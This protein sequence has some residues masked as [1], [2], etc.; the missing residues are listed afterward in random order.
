MNIAAHK[1][2]VPV[3]VA[4]HFARTPLAMK[5]RATLSRKSKASRGE[6]AVARAWRAAKRASFLGEGRAAQN[7]LQAAG[8]RGVPNASP[9]QIIGGLKTLAPDLA[10]GAGSLAVAAWA[11]QKLNEKYKSMIP[12]SLQQHAPALLS[13]AIGIGGYAAARKIRGLNRF[14]LAILMGGVSAAVVHALASSKSVIP[15][16]V[17]AENKPLPDVEVSWGRRLCWPTGEYNSMGEYTSVGEYTALGGSIF[18]QSSLGGRDDDP[19]FVNGMDD[20]PIFAE[21]DLEGSLAGGIF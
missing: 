6:K 3:R 12:A 13:A 21:D 2:A 20:A 15:G 4:A 7:Y 19:V 17:D 9:G 14:S 5:A 16:G 18:S 10:V 11:G 1:A 8:M